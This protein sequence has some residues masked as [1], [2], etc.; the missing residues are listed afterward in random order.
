MQASDE[1]IRHFLQAFKR[2]LSR[3][4]WEI[5]QRRAEYASV[6]QMN[7]DDIIMILMQLTPDDYIAGPEVD[8]NRPTELLWKFRRDQS[9]SDW[10]YIKLKYVSG[11]AKVISFHKSIY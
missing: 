5:V 11:L 10:L 9:D 3:G 1:M 7:T 2:A 6:T 4:D 8:R